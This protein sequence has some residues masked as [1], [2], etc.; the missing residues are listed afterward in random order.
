MAR[1][2]CST[3]QPATKPVTQAELEALVAKGNTQPKF[4]GRSFPIGGLALFGA[5]KRLYS[6][7]LIDCDLTAQDLTELGRCVQAARFVLTRSRFPAGSLAS[8]S[9]VRLVALDL[10]GAAISDAD[11][12][13]VGEISS[14]T[15]LDL[16]GT[17]IGD[18]GVRHL[19]ELTQLRLLHLSGTKVTDGGLKHLSGLA[20]LEVLGLRD[21][22]VTDAGLLHLITCK[23]LRLNLE[24]LAGSART[25]AGVDAAFHA[26]RSGKSPAVTK[27]KAAPKPPAPGE[28]PPAVQALVGFFADYEAW[29]RK[30]SKGKW[31]V[32]VRASARA[33]LLQR[34]CTPRLQ[35]EAKHGGYSNPPRFD[36]KTDE[37]ERVTARGAVT[38]VTTRRMEPLLRTQTRRQYTLKLVGGAWLLDGVKVS[39]GASF[40]RFLV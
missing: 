38:T 12:A 28:A 2:K 13:C 10:S 17:G 14:L 35:A 9:E 4:E 21:T 22:R 32:T 24:M 18:E 34:W 31:S 39:H 37:I 16:S 26:R 8:L 29:S 40:T 27:T 25:Q 19:A 33:S 36:T 23:R 1:S 20:R 30:A 7:S 3:R 5:T 6:I 11:L 15:D